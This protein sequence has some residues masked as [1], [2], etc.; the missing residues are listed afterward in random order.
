MKNAE[1]NYPK[2][3]LWFY[4]NIRGRSDEN[5][6]SVKVAVFHGELLEFVKETEHSMQECLDKGNGDR[7]G[8]GVA[9]VLAQGAS[10]HI[11]IKKNRVSCSTAREVPEMRI[12]A[13]DDGG[14]A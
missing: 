12:D 8:A 9:K 4:F 7:V 3:R 6:P 10:G 13:V 2:G 1:V 11:R 14:M 5:I